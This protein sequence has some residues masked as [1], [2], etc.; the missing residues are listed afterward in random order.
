MI[1]SYQ[2]YLQLPM[3]RARALTQTSAGNPNR[4]HRFVH[5]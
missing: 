4:A 1:F 3:K 5:N 2:V